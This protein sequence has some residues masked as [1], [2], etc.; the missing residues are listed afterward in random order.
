[1]SPGFG[2]PAPN[3][4]AATAIAGFG[5]SEGFQG[6]LVHLVDEIRCQLGCQKSKRYVS[7]AQAY[8]G[9]QA[10][11]LGKNNGTS[12]TSGFNRFQRPAKWEFKIHVPKVDSEHKAYLIYWQA[13]FLGSLLTMAGA[14]VYNI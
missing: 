3:G 12:G 13:L 11:K 2:A 4:A 9:L 7:E 8:K 10:S 1:M 6:V 14:C 5:V